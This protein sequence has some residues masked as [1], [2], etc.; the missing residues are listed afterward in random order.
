MGRLADA[1]LNVALVAAGLLVL[2]LLYGLAA[3]TFTSRPD[4]VPEAAPEALT[5]D[6]IQVEVRNG[7]GTSGLAA[8]L[9]RHLRRQGFDVIE[10]GNFSSFDVDSTFVVDRIGDG[11]AAG[12]VA[13]AVG[14]P[15]ARVRVDT[16][17]GRFLDVSIVIGRDYA[18][19]APFQADSLIP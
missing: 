7:A 19:F 12:R 1:F 3:R 16:A 10:S 2:V 17:G 15:P 9:T 6:V 11:A 18:A 8:V 14:V 4:P 13:D 5:G